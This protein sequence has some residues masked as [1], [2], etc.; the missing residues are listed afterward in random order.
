MT[1][2]LLDRRLLL[3]TGKGG[4]GK[5]SVTASLALLAAQHGTKVLACEVDAKGNLADF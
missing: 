5:T 4:T 1:V 3:V 2:P